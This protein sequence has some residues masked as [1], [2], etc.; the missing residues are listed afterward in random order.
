MWS[1]CRSEGDF[2]RNGEMA[3]E[4]L[5]ANGVQTL[6][7]PGVDLRFLKSLKQ[8]LDFFPRQVLHE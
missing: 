6:R 3:R 5:I 2:G 1:G 7:V 4:L 8:T